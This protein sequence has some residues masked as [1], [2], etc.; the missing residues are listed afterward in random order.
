VPKFIFTYHQTAGYV[1]GS[2]PAATAAWGSYFDHIADS[3]LDPGQPVA[4]R[5]ALGEVGSTTQLGG[6]SVV[7]AADMEHAVALATLCPALASGGGV[8]VGELMELPPEHLA[9]RLR[10]KL[11]RA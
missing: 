2:D 5:T 1:P 8:Q 10:D 11:S 9:A 7:D 6:Y 3:V 4:H